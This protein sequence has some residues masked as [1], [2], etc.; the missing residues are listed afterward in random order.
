M[1]ENMHNSNYMCCKPVQW[2][3]K[4][5]VGWYFLICAFSLQ[6][7]EINSDIINNSDTAI[8]STEQVYAD[9]ATDNKT[10]L[11]KANLL[12]LGIGVANAGVEY[13]FSDRF[14]I[15]VPITYSP[16][17]IKRTYKLRTLSIQPE[18][19]WWMENQLSGHFFGFH[20]HLAY[21]N[22]ALN[23]YDR[24][25]DKGGKTPLLGFG[26]SYGYALKGKGRWNFE[27]TAGIGYAH[28]KYDVF[29]N[30]RNGA[31]YNTK[32]KNYFGLTKAGV[33]LIYK[34]TTRN[35]D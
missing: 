29:Y 7:Q 1:R 2:S 13:S 26:F 8:K 31:D 21:Y 34:L 6:A 5:L 18:L 23:S 28:L 35:D 3:F 4:F 32:S 33:T 14:S 25:Q 22:V 19:R 16:Y 24:Y 9:I 30:V 20:A 11:V 27:F 17:T 12:Q 10:W 15:D